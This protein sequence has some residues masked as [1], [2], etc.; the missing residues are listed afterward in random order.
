VGDVDEHESEKPS[1]LQGVQHH[2]GVLSL[3]HTSASVLSIDGTCRLCRLGGAAACHLLPAMTIRTDD[4][5]VVSGSTVVFKHAGVEFAGYGAII[6]MTRLAGGL[7]CPVSRL[8]ALAPVR[9]LGNRAYG[10][11]ARHRHT[12]SRVLPGVRLT[13]LD[14]RDG[15]RN[16]KPLDL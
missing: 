1:A 7:G 14:A 11:V 4:E 3:P 15:P 16:D 10:W 12:I 8:L 2:E 9:L 13:Q 6:E 5:S